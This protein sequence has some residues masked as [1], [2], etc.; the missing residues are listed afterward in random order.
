M[1]SLEYIA[2]V[3]ERKVCNACPKLINPSSRPQLDSDEIGPWTRLHG[4]LDARIMVVG[5]DWGDLKY[6]EK[7]GGLDKP[8]NPTM[9]AL[10]SLLAAVG[11]DAPMDRYTDKDKNV[12]LTNAILCLKSGGLQ[13]AVEKS[14]FANCAERFL[15]RQVELVRPR[16][17]VPLGEKAYK[18]L[19]LAFGLKQ[20][21]LR[22][23][24]SHP[25]VELLPGTKMVPVYHCGK[26]IQNTHRPLHIQLQDWE[27]VQTALA[28]D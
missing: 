20:G 17:V 28:E 16:V 13:G 19:C 27:R 10:Q 5:Q 9:V 4:D 11:V 2:L 6:Y 21:P 15:R 26:R 18:A 22:E 25:G 7:N 8:T 24:V 12:F 23:A 14:W 1:K 3:A